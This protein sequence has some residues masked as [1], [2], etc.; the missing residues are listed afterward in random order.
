MLKSL[1]WQ[2]LS[3]RDFQIFVFM[4]FFQVFVLAFFNNF[5]MI[6]TEHLIPPDVLPSL[7]KSIMYGAGFMC[8]QVLSLFVSFCPVVSN[9]NADY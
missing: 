6:F 5:T 1:T 4:N 9:D 7:A 2:I 3:N 8:P